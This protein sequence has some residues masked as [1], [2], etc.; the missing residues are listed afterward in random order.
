M[1]TIL[2]ASQPRV[3]PLLS[4][5]T[6]AIPQRLAQLQVLGAEIE[7]Q[8]VGVE[9]KVEW[10]A[11]VDPCG[12]RTIG[13][14]RD[15]LVQLARGRFVAFVDDDDAISPEYVTYLLGAIR[16]AD[17]KVSVITFRQAA[18]WNGQC[19]TVEFR[20]GQL[21]APFAVGGVTQRNAWHVCAWRSTLA[22]AHHFPATNYGE[23]WAWA[24]HLC[25]TAAGEIHIPLV[26]HTYTHHENTT[27]APA[28]TA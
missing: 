23:D 16:E 27:A 25:L 19:S 4:I 18:S 14:K 8:R 6:P 7:R 2:Y 12:H 21:N 1:S 9:E 15:E 28:P 22:K 13:E 26:L 5:L 10:L 17:E 3:Q 11:L 20:L 24:R